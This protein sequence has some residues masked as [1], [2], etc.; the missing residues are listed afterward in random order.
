MPGQEGRDTGMNTVS[1]SCSSLAVS[2]QSTLSFMFRAGSWYICFQCKNSHWIPIQHWMFKS[3]IYLKIDCLIHNWM[4]LI[5]FNFQMWRLK[6]VTD[7]GQS[8]KFAV[9]IRWKSSLSITTLE[10]QLW[11]AFA[12]WMSRNKTRQE[13]HSH[14]KDWFWI[15]IDASRL[16]WCHNNVIGSHNNEKCKYF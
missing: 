1:P 10:L 8:A 14:A 12:F 11:I 5:H 13:F 9:G 15:S 4:S 7:L 3:Y 6:M 2:R 16:K